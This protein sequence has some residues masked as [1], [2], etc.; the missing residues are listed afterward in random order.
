MQIK[1]SQMK[2]MCNNNSVLGLCSS[3]TKVISRDFINITESYK[4]TYAQALY[5]D[6]TRGENLVHVMLLLNSPW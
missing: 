4:R 6:R 1:I 5:K 3:C 2:T